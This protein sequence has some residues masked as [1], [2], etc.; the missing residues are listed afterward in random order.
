MGI[1]SR[2]FIRLAHQAATASSAL[3]GNSVRMP[4]SNVAPST[5]KPIR[6]LPPFN[7]RQCLLSLSATMNTRYN[8]LPRL[9][10]RRVTSVR[11]LTARRRN[12]HLSQPPACL[13]V[14]CLR[15]LRPHVQ[16]P[17][18]SAALVSCRREHHIERCPQPKRAPSPTANNGVSRAAT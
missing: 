16:R 12:R 5:S 1:V 6:F 3:T 11:N 18:V 17:L 15:Q 10:I 2:P 8:A 7:G 9:F 14:Q 4:S 13:S